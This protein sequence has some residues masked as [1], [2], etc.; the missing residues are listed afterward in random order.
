MTQRARRSGTFPNEATRGLTQIDALQ[1]HLTDDF[2]RILHVEP[3]L[4]PLLDH[5]KC[6]AGRF[7]RIGIG[8]SFN[9]RHQLHSLALVQLRRTARA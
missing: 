2:H 8:A 4:D 1:K 3:I 9:L 7:A 5:G 6:P